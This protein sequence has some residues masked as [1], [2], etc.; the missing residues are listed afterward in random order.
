[1]PW[2]LLGP[3]LTRGTW[4]CGP[5][6]VRPP[7]P[8]QAHNFHPGYAHGPAPDFGDSGYFRKTPLGLKHKRR[9]WPLWVGGGQSCTLGLP[10]GHRWL[11]GRETPALGFT[12][13]PSPARRVIHLSLLPA[14]G[15]VG[16]TAMETVGEEQKGQKK[17]ARA[18][19]QAVP[20][21]LWNSSHRTNAPRAPAPSCCPACAPRPPPSW[22]LSLGHL[23]WVCLSWSAGV[24]A[25][26][27]AWAPL[28]GS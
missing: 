18:P 23:I 28:L 10:P 1:M 15:A 22:A 17:E 6:P 25:P 8:A 11:G 3:G 7:F 13:G 27:C 21:V 2:P 4:P 19:A 14:E 20:R 9:P 5:C 16:P 12:K 26:T 24:P